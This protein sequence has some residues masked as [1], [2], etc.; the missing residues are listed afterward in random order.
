MALIKHSKSQRLLKEA[1]VLDMGDL[2]KQAERILH[3]ARA[4]AK[5]IHERAQVEAKKLIDAADERG[6]TD[7][8]ER[9]HAEG[10]IAGEKQGAQLALAERSTQIDQLIT[11][12]SG[13]LKSWDESRAAILQEARDDIL[14]FAIEVAKRVVHR[15][16]QIDGSIVADQISAALALLSRPTT[17]K[18][19][20]H[21]HD[22]PLVDGILPELIG[23]LGSSEHV[24]IATDESITRGGCIISTE[25]G[26][27]DATIDTQ[28][29]RIAEGVVPIDPMLQQPQNDASTST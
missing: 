7:G 22:R 24:S 23:K 8:F 13:A 17:I 25:G 16:V 26:R 2:A 3:N 15:T 29:Q 14:R 27:V 10:V 11:Q 18:V 20:I 9:G 4:E 1:I 12:W 19:A 6:Y 28:L 21:P 5:Q